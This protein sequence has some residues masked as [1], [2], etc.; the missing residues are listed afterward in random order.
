MFR[1][2]SF[3]HGTLSCFLNDFPTGNIWLKLPLPS[4]L[5]TVLPSISATNSTSHSFFLATACLWLETFL[6]GVP[7]KMILRLSPSWLP[8]SH[9]WYTFCLVVSENTV[10]FHCLQL[11]LS[12]ATREAAS[13]TPFAFSLLRCETNPR[14]FV[15]WNFTTNIN[16][17]NWLSQSPSH[18]FSKQ[19]MAWLLQPQLCISLTWFPDSFSTS[20]FL[21]NMGVFAT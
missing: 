9:P 6:D 21:W 13:A 1:V 16:L 20:I 11:G 14:L 4:W 2:N 12:S 15:T 7:L 5:F 18:R 19:T 10:C 8:T 3:I 17:S